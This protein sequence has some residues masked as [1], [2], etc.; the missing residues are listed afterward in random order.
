MSTSYVNNLNS[1]DKRDNCSQVSFP[2]GGRNPPFLAR[3][4]ANSYIKFLSFKKK[5]E[6]QSHGLSK[7][8]VI[9][10][11]PFHNPLSIP[12]IRVKMQIGNTKSRRGQY[13]GFKV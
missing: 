4:N 6:K 7:K 13:L 3:E 12:D 8:D 9:I 5:R 2:G 10:G 1:N 11:S